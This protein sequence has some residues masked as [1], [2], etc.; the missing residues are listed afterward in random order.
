VLN[1]IA[2][3]FEVLG[4]TLV[5]LE[6]YRSDTASALEAWINQRI[7]S[8]FSRRPKFFWFMDEDKPLAFG[9]FVV[10]LITTNVATFAYYFFERDQNIFESYWKLIVNTS[11]IAGLSG[12]VSIAWHL[13]R[14]P[15][16]LLSILP[17]L[18]MRLS[19][20]IHPKGSA[21]AGTG[22]MVAVVGLC[23]DF[24]QAALQ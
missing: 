21:V 20:A 12:V 8:M 19:K 4:L 18:L 22:V 1:W 7:S 24:Y 16:F 17:W 23:I 15:I 3:A 10:V 14:L 2:L 6:V 11:I 5:C 9:L 13:V